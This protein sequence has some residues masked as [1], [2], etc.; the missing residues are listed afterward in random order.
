MSSD[1]YLNPDNYEFCSFINSDILENSKYVYEDIDPDVN[2][3]DKKKSTTRYYTPNQLRHLFKKTNEFSILHM[4]CRSLNANFS[5]IEY[6]T[7]ELNNAFDILA[8]TETWLNESNSDIFQMCG[9]EFCHQ[10]RKGRRGGVVGILIKQGIKYKVIEKLTTAIENIFE[11]I[12]VE[13]SL[14]RKVTVS[15]V[16]RQPGS[17]LE[18]FTKCVE[19][20]FTTKNVHCIC[21]VTIT[22]SF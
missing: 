2:F 1:L 21:V 13:L 8:V 6:L 11:C 14:N 7:K 10:P 12:S 20:M 4:N 17:S 3:L 19:N 15:C 5:S 22:L 9:L 18:E 16:H